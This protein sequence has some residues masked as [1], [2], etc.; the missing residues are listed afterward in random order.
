[1]RARYSRAGAAGRNLA[2]ARAHAILRAGGFMHRRGFTLVELAFVLTVMSVLVAVSVPGYHQVM[3]QARASEA[4]AMLSAL[5]HTVS[6]YQR[7]HAEVLECLP[8]P[9]E[10][11][12]T[13]AVRFVARPC[14]KALGFTIDGL[15]RYRYQVKRG[16]TGF[17]VIAEGD[18]NGDSVTSS[19][20]LSSRDLRV[21]TEREFE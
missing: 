7:D 10:P 21:T 14:W 13:T 16:A 18:L 2:P 19:F 4:R 12:P 20:T 1:M 5:H 15:V 11:V 8:L 3:L 9:D 6:V 17:E